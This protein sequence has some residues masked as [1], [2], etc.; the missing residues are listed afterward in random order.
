MA[1]S[2]CIIGFSHSLAP[3]RKQKLA[4]DRRNENGEDERADQREG[5]GP[6][7]GLEEPAFDSLQR[8]DGQVRS[9][10]DAAGKEDRPLHLVGRVA[11]LLRGCARVVLMGKMA[12]HVFDHH[13]RA[14]DHHAEVQR[15]QREQVGGNVAQVEAD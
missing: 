15:A 13:H 9:D 4:I 14:V 10:D 6:G 7:H 12:D 2:H 5:D 11:N 8:E 3:L 1:V